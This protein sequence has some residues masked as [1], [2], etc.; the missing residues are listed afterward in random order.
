VSSY[1]NS[2]PARLGLELPSNI[3]VLCEVGLSLSRIG[4]LSFQAQRKVNLSIPPN[5]WIGKA[6]TGKMKISYTATNTKAVH[7]V[8]P[9]L[10][11]TASNAYVYGRLRGHGLNVMI[12]HTLNL[13]T[14]LSKWCLVSV[15]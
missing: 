8:Q 9:I 14:M 13:A 12:R 7:I 1:A 3:Y 11:H 6:D 2:A 10:G 5:T 4:W 15:M